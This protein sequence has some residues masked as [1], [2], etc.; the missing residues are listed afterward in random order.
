MAWFV[1]VLLGDAGGILASAWTLLEVVTG[2]YISRAFQMSD[3][4]IAGSGWSAGIFARQNLPGGQNPTGTSGTAKSP[5]SVQAA[6][7]ANAM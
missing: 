3:A 1:S 5:A 4:A 7:L 2:H 6:F